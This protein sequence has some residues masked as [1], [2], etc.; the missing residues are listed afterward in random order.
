MIKHTYLSFSL[1]KDATEPLDTIRKQVDAG[2]GCT[3]TD[4]NFGGVQALVGHIL[5]I[6]IGLL[7][8]RG[9]DGAHVYQ[10]HGDTDEHKLTPR[11]MWEEIRIDDAI[12][13]L[14]HRRGAGIWRTPSVEERIAEG[15]YDLSDI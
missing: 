15:N 7:L 3:L 9:I 12:I 4:G 11:H 5:G 6:H 1:R 14:L 2:L 10:L 13:N 8:W